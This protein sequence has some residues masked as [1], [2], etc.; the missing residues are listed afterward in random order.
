MTALMA[1]LFVATMVVGVPIGSALLLG[2][3]GAV[4]LLG[5]MPSNIVI[6]NLFRPMQ[7]F[8][9]VAIPFFIMSGA[10]MMSGAMGQKIIGLA[11]MLVGRFRGGAGTG[12]RAGLGAVRRRIGFGGG[13]YLGNG[14][15]YDPLDGT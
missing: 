12:Q 8:T 5:D 3:T 13:R 7:N 1:G 9:L 2:G 4:V 15:G 11:S 6:M 14:C 10:L